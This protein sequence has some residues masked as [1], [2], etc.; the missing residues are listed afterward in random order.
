MMPSTISMRSL[1]ISCVCLFSFSAAAQ[2][3][4][5]NTLY[6]KYMGIGLKNEL[7]IS[8]AGVQ[9][10]KVKAKF[11]GK[12]VMSGDSGVYEVVLDSTSR[13]GDSCI[14]QV[15][16]GTKFLKRY[17]LIVINIP[18]PITGICP[19]RY[20][21]DAVNGGYVTNKANLKNFDSLCF[22]RQDDKYGIMNG[23]F[24][25][26]SFQIIIMSKKEGM[27]TQSCST[28]SI[29]D[30]FKLEFAK[31]GPGDMIVI[32]QVKVYNKQLKK[33]FSLNPITI[34]LQ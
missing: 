19:M 28:N 29:G 26:Q 5:L 24:S 12:G 6:K 25:Y 13:E 1:A 30:E 20:T 33:E 3:V 32:D 22:T 23:L 10:G 21:V 11:T 7:R 4:K 31:L 16:N 34:R 8:I 18:K 2:E 17:K 27:I 9:P 14:V 15:F